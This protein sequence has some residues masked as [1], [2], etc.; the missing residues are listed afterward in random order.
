MLSIICSRSKIVLIIRL[1]NLS[2]SHALGFFTATRCIEINFIMSIVTKRYPTYGLIFSNCRTFRELWLKWTVVAL[3]RKKA[4][5]R[6]PC[7]RRLKKQNRLIEIRILP[8]MNWY[9]YYEAWKQK[10][11]STP[12]SSSWEMSFQTTYGVKTFHSVWI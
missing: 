3:L 9:N 10:L 12:A 8:P 2:F 6:P 7:L 5:I 4:V 1:I 11:H